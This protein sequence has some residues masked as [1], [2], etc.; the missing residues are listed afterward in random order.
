MLRGVIKTFYEEH[1]TKTQKIK[2]KKETWIH[3][4]NGDKKW[5]KGN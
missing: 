5:K 3:G 1:N 2:S 4:K